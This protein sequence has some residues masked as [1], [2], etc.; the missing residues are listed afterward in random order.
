MA[1]THALILSLFI[2]LAAGAGALAAV[3]TAH[4]AGSPAAAGAPKSQ[5]AALRA[6]QNL[7]DRQRAALRRALAKRPPKLPKVPNF[8][9]VAAPP[10]QAPAATAQASIPAAATTVT[11]RVRYVRPA[12]IVVVNHSS[13]G[14]D[15]SEHEDGHEGGGD[16]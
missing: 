4:L 9:P 13:H 7:L 15:Q 10:A 1:R 12:P 6:R 5:S 14:D 2:G 3:Q 11:P 16:D 8:A